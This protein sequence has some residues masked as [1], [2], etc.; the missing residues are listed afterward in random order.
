MNIAEFYGNKLLSKY[1]E[2]AW[3][4]LT[5]DMAFGLQQFDNWEQVP[6]DVQQL[7]INKVLEND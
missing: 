2:K 1:E 7:Y 3:A 6:K 4:L 5:E